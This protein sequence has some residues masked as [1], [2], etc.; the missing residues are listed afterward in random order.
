[1]Y[2]TSTLSRALTEDIGRL[3]ASEPGALR[4]AFAIYRRIREEAPVFRIGPMVVVADYEHVKQVLGDPDNFS[5]S[6]GGSRM[7]ALHASLSAEE[8][9]QLSKV[10][11][12]QHRWVTHHDGAEH[13]RLRGLVQYA[14]TPKKINTMRADIQS[15]AD[16]LLP[17][18]R[19]GQFDLVDEFAFPLPLQ[20][21][22]GLVSLGQSDATRLKKWSDA[23]G[24]AQSTDYANRAEAAEAVDGFH[25]LIGQAIVERRRTGNAAGVFGALVVG[26]QDLPERLTDD[27]I[28]AM[29]TLLLFAG[30][31]TTVNL[32]SNAVVALHENP[33][34][35]ELLLANPALIKPALSEFLRH[36]GS[37]QLTHRM[38]V[39]DVELAGVEIHPGDTVRCL[40]A[41]ANRDESV[42][43]DGDRFDVQRNNARAHLGMGYGIHT[44]LGIWLAQLETEV[45]ITTLLERYPNFT[46]DGKWELRPQLVLRGPSSLPVSLA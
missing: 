43:P 21:I 17:P 34:Q 23:I 41:S 4:D 3:F 5:A 22:V 40:F 20:V 12:F 46:I 28:V 45:A 9:A 13:R 35:K 44:C 33:E 6:R 29:F 19:R 24:R 7:E 18:G 31:E 30:H 14:F 11:D 8:S 26:A 36:S 15:L 39:A 37:V 38:A 10:V 25:E 2:E 42:F 16:A 1:M 27:E 32:I